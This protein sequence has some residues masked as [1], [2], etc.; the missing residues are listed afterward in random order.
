MAGGRGTRFGPLTED[1]CKP[2]VPFGKNRLIDFALANAIN[3]RVVDHIMVLTQYKQQGLLKHLNQFDLNN[4]IW[5]KFVDMVPA[6]QQLGDSW[7]TG[8]AN[9]VYQ[10][11]KDIERD[12]ADTVVVLSADH[13]YKLYIPQMLA[14]HYDKEAEFTV[15][16]MVM[17]TA[18]AAGNFGVMEVDE[19]FHIIGFEEK[20]VKPKTIPSMEGMCFA[21]MGIYIFNKKFLL[22]VLEEDHK[23]LG[24]KH[25]FGKDVI[26]RAIKQKARGYGYDHDTNVVPGEVKI[27]DGV[28][29][30]VCYWRD[31]GKIGPYWEALMD[32]VAIDPQMNLYNDKWPIPTAW[33]MLPPAKFIFPDKEYYLSQFG[34]VL[35]DLVGHNFLPDNIVAGGCIFDSPKRFHRVVFGRSVRTL[36]GTEI[37]RSIIFDGAEIGS[38]TSLIHT[39]VEEGVSIPHGARVGFN[40]EEDESNGV[41]IDEYHNAKWNHSPIRVVT[42]NTHFK[43]HLKQQ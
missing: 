7:Y 33:D 35:D 38:K 40:L 18:E 5:G 3:S 8:T 17:P 15:C 41:Y 23:H 39:I 25:D 30:H 1:R 14:Y 32:L 19:D 42:K 2:E 13:I 11:H 31:V 16:G 21:S 6:S 10:N 22:R 24:S 43:A 29:R 12:P 20:P 26:P 28:E 4:H 36:F 37:D 27:V 9:A 34:G